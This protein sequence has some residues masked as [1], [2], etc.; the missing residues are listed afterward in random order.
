MLVEKKESLGKKWETVAS[1]LKFH[2]S[3][4]AD[5]R[6]RYPL[7]VTH[8]PFPIS[9]FPRVL[10]ARFLGVH[11]EARA[12]QEQSN[13]QRASPGVIFPPHR[14]VAAL[15]HPHTPPAGCSTCNNV[16]WRVGGGTFIIEALERRPP[17]PKNPPGA[18]GAH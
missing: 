14:H 16:V 1:V 17:L 18:C 3:L 11:V 2:A 4:D 8:F 10:G 13:L 12:L 15:P 5:A 9:H 6:A 7:P